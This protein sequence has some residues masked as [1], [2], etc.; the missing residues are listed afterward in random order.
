MQRFT[1]GVTRFANGGA[2]GEDEWKVEGGM[3]M[4]KPGN[5]VGEGRCEMVP[6][7]STRS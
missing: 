1:P 6:E 4:Q 3:S 2:I 7:L 5:G